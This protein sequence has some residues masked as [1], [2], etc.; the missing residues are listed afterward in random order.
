MTSSSVD[1]LLALTLDITRQLRRTMRT[2]CGEEKEV[3][4]LQLHAVALIKEHDG[5]TMKEFAQYL[6]ITSPSATS[7][8]NRLVSVG[9]VKRVP[10][11]TNRKLVR[12]RLSPQG[13]RM[14]AIKLQER[15]GVLKQMLATLSQQDQRDLVRI[16]R[17]LSHSL[18]SSSHS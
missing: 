17:K 12:L 4:M 9:W 15:R 7:F 18:N 1:E 14:F 16:L 6:K 8:I 13:Q 2:L 10:D 5:M 3:N 11:S